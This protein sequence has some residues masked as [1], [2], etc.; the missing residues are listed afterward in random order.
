[1]CEEEGC[2]A[3]VFSTAVNLLDRFLCECCIVK[4]QLQMVAC[5]CL[6][7]ASKVRQ[8]N[9]LTVSR[10]VYFTDNSVTPEDIRVSG[11]FMSVK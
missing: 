2:E 11:L 3:Q 1:M 9:A 6:L 4:S 5:V 10:L 7:V 8:C